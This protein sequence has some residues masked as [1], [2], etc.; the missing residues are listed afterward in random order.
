[1]DTILIVGAADT[2]RSPM[3]AALLA[4]LLAPRAPGCRVGSAGVLGHDD[5]P[6]ETEARDTMVLMGLD[7]SE[8]RA[9][10]VSD[11]LIDEALLVVG[12]DSG[13][14]RVLLG[15][16]PGAVARI[17]S[18]GDLAGRRRDIPDPFRMQIGAWLSYGREL[19]ELLKAALP[20]LLQRVPPELRGTPAVPAAQPAEAPPA[21]APDPS[22][23]AAALE[24]LGLLLRVA[25]EL[26]GVIDWSAARGVIDAE[27]GRA[28]QPEGPADLAPAYAG[29]L[30]AALALSTMPPT[31]G[32]IGALRSALDALAR[33][34][35]Q[36]DLTRLSVQLGGWGNLS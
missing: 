19:E 34:L 33:P 23:R 25:A 28:C 17:T 20:Q 1:M 6:A 35:A 30:R 31:P 5:D 11:A 21:P 7:I 2:S 16:F 32:Q 29:L 36:D 8:H 12:I 24:R 26:P 22:G 3:A 18:L 27:L 15:R 13:T 9:R 10:S 14:T 4:R